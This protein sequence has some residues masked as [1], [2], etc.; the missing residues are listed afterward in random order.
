VTEIL[1]TV[2]VALA[3]CGCVRAL[4][5]MDDHKQQPAKERARREREIASWMMK[6]MKVDWWTV[7]AARAARYSCDQCKRERSGR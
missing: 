1:E 2:A 7:D 6:R 3:P 5:C 4:M